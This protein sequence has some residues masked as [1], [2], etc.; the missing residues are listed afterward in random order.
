[1][2]D[3]FIQKRLFSPFDSTKGLTGMGIGV[4]ES[5]NVIQAMGGDIRVSSLPG[6]GTSFFVSIPCLCCQHLKNA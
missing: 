6:K 5:R 2:S 3:E 1:M 4:F